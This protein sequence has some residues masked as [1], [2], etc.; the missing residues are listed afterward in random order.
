MVYGEEMHKGVTKS[1][2]N[3]CHHF[4]EK[5]V[6]VQD[7]SNGTADFGHGRELIGTA[8]EVLV[9]PGALHSNGDIVSQGA[10]D[11][12]VRLVETLRLVTL[13]IEHAQHAILDFERQSHFGSGV[14]QRVHVAV[15]GFVLH[16]I[17][18][19]FHASLGHVADDPLSELDLQEGKRRALVGLG[20]GGSG[21]GP[22]TQDLLARF[23]DEESHVVMLEGMEDK[24]RHA[25]GEFIQVEDVG[26]LGTDCAYQRELLDPPTLNRHLAGGLQ[27][28]GRLGGQEVEKSDLS[29]TERRASGTFHLQHAQNGVTGA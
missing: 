23:Q 7:G 21:A 6:Q 9:E 8:S 13:H 16:V 1:L 20:M 26:D 17:G 5:G 25:A 28:N 24:V 14:R 27:G 11:E 29:I 10:Q 12:H 18:Q 3:E 22:A 4:I 2:V 19:E 15:E